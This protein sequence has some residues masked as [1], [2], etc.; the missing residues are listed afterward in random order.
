M[1]P[2]DR[3]RLIVSL[4]RADAIGCV[5]VWK[6]DPGLKSSLSLGEK[7]EMRGVAIVLGPR[8]ERE[9]PTRS[10]LAFTSTATQRPQRASSLVSVVCVWLS[11][12]ESR[13][14]ERT[15]TNC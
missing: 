8:R 7:R 11:L 9:T 14:V 13:I 2:F 1:Q 5:G 4:E 10:Y 15:F 6:S 12:R 3:N